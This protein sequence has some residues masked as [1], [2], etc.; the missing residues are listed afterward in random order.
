MT[1]NYNT[2]TR[3]TALLYNPDLG[4]GGLTHKS[5]IFQGYKRT[6]SY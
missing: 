3:K 1:T 4:E 6:T 5:H 2:V